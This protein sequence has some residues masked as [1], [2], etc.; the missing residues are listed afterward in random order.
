MS[1]FNNRRLCLS[2]VE[3]KQGKGV[4]SISSGERGRK[5]NDEFLESKMDDGDAPSSNSLSFSVLS[6][7]LFVLGFP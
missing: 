7:S 2:L 5:K 1:S 4:F 6:I 3:S